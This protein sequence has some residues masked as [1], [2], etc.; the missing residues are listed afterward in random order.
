VTTAK[1]DGAEFRDECTVSGPF[2]AFMQPGAARDAQIIAESIAIA[3]PNVTARIAR[4]DYETST[5]YFEP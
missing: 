2:S 3:K 5:I 4:I 1:T